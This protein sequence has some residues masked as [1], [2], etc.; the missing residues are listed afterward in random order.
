M[1]QWMIAWRTLARRPGYS[2]T[3]LLML[4]LG[5]GATSTLFSVVDTI[6][7]KPLPYPNADRLVTVY[8]ASPATNNPSSLIAPVRLEEWNRLNRSFD[9]IAGLYTENVTDTSGAEPERLAGRR[10]SPRYFEVYGTPPMLGRTFAPNE[11]VFGGPLTAVISYGFWTRRYARD[12]RAIGKRLT[13][14]GAGCTIVGVMPSQFSAPSVDVWL[15]AQSN[16]QLMT[17]R[18]ARFYNGVGRMKPGVSIAQARADLASVER[19][20][21]AEYPATDKGWSA[22]VDDLKEMRVGD[23]RRTLLLVFGAVALLMLIAIAN[24]AGLTTAQLQQREREMAIRSSIGASRP[25]VIATV[26][27][28]VLLLAALGA[29]FGGA[30]AYLGVELFAKLFADLPRVPELAF[31]W[32]ALGFT[33]LASIAA[34]AIFGLIP[35]IQ[36]TRADLAPMLAESAR[37]VAGGRRR[38][39]QSLVVAQLALTVLLLSS[40][41]LLLRT[42]YNLSHVDTGFD[43]SNVVT[44]HVGAAWNEDRHKIGLLQERL[45]ADIGRLPGVEAAGIVNLLPAL[46]ATQTYQMQLEGVARTEETAAST[47]G[48]RGVSAGYLQALK[49][50]LLAGEWCPALKMDF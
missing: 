1:K 5:I 16:P 22:L 26:M 47:V 17:I 37:G 2:L 24:I 19:G 14:G 34:A 18:N 4:I 10:V 35:A 41:G 48:Q 27:R 23:Y 12:P 33:A 28:E 42:Y 15:P 9:T 6:L 30:V 46:G 3:A 49:Y 25:Q 43:A 29:A 36:A 45:I 20:L 44:F 40:A 13:I 38:W 31:D 8:E 32:R 21:A 11:E 7:L 39:Q 50:P